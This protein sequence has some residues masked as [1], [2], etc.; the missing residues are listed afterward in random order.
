MKS[1]YFFSISLV[2]LAVPLIS[3]AEKMVI[4][5]VVYQTQNKGW[6][7]DKTAPKESIQ[8]LNASGLSAS[9]L[10]KEKPKKEKPTTNPTT[11]PGITSLLLE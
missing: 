2:I 9:T 10:S 5:G 7:A 1:L 4:K 8:S 3:H 6:I 11:S